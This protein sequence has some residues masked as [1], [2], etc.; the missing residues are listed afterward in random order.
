MTREQGYNIFMSFT[1]RLKFYQLGEVCLNK[2]SENFVFNVIYRTRQQHR[3]WNLKLDALLEKNG[4]L[5]NDYFRIIEI[6]YFDLKF[7]FVSDSSI[8]KFFNIDICKNDFKERKYFDMIDEKYDEQFILVFIKGKIQSDIQLFSD[9]NYSMV[10]QNRTN[11]NGIWKS[12]SIYYEFKDSVFISNTK[13]NNYITGNYIVTDDV[14]ILD[15]QSEKIKDKEILRF[16]LY[17]DSLIVDKVKT[18]ERIYLGRNYGDNFPD[19]Y[20][21]EPDPILIF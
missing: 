21:S 8:S 11:L 2:L 15:Y 17:L 13:S 1:N 10:I 7:T 20:V 19:F 9:E 18:N 12:E 6:I 16:Q 4:I 5:D 14:I 3:Q